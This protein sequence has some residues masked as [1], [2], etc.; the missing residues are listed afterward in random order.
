VR[1][2]C[3]LQKPEYVNFTGSAVDNSGNVIRR[4]PQ[5]ILKVTPTASFLSDRVRV[6]VSFAHVGRRFANDANTIA[7][8]AF[9]KLDASLQLDLRHRWR[10]VLSGD[11]LTDSA[12]LTEG[13]PRT[14]LSDPATGLYM[15]RPLFGRSFH[16]A[17]SKSF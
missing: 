4:I 17:L 13:N 6:S 12:G 16:A 2:N 15:A 1:W 14:D 7:L 3:T 5:Q 8:P 10:L 9:D 11:N